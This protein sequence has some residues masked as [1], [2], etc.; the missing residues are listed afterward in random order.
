ML[1]SAKV[2]VPDSTMEAWGCACQDSAE[3][4]VAHGLGCIVLAKEAA[5]NVG[6][7][8]RRGLS[9]GQL[10]QE[11]LHERQLVQQGRHARGVW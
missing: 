1:C 10:V 9:F 8:P 6:H 3:A 5:G 2:W 4:E 11:E 7:A